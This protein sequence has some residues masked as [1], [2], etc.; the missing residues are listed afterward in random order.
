[1]RRKLLFMMSAM[2]LATAGITYASKVPTEVASET[3]EKMYFSCPNCGNSL[4]AVASN[5]CGATYVKCDKCGKT[6]EVSHQN[7]QIRSIRLLR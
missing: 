6:T 1:M 7:G 2:L 5:N 3:G 4:Y